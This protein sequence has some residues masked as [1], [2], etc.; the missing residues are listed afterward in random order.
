MKKDVWEASWDNIDDTVYSKRNIVSRLGFFILK[1]TLK[2]IIDKTRLKKSS[3]IIEVGC[4]SGKGLSY[5]REFGFKNSIGID[6][7][8]NALRNCRARGFEIKKDV[9][10]MNASKTKFKK[11]S[12]DLVYSEGLLEHYKNFTPI[13][14]EFSRISRRYILIAQPDHYSFLGK[15][16]NK[17]VS[18]FEKGHVKEYSYRMSDFV[19]AFK[20]LGFEIKIIKGT[21]LKYLDS[22]DTSK[23]LLFEKVK[24]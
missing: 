9:F 7:S 23:L 5:F 2:N 13:A 21:H 16:L 3:R 6:Y 8:L 22:L 24:K 1:K 11:A 20:K 17:I 4:G 15:M 14:K 10:L 12:F 19:N 18:R